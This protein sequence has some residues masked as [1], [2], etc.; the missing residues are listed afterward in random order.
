MIIKNYMCFNKVLMKSV[1]QLIIKIVTGEFILGKC[2]Y[3]VKKYIFTQQKNC[4]F[5]FEEFIFEFVNLKN[6][7]YHY[8]DWLKYIHQKWKFCSI[9]T[10]FV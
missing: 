9:S 6:W 8:S 7:C 2:S 4:I 5:D 3:E 10:F 1:P